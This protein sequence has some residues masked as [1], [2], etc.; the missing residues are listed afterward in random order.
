MAAV[1]AGQQVAQRL[2]R[3]GAGGQHDVLAGVRGLGR[4]RLVH[5]GLADPAGAERG[6]HAP[7]AAHPGH[8]AVRPGRRA[9]RSRWVSRSSRP[10]HGRQPLDDVAVEGHAAS[11]SKRPTVRAS[12]PTPSGEA[13]TA[14]MRPLANRTGPGGVLCAAT[15]VRVP[16]CR[17]FIVLAEWWGRE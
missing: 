3:R 9:V 15:F 11:M 7:G 14:S 1:S 8:A 13:V 10:G 2:A 6:D 5:P 4:D 17:G 16:G 12:A